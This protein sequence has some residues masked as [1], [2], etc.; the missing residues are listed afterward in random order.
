MVKRQ[1]FTL[2]E[3]I[4][5]LV[6]LVMITGLVQMAGPLTNQ[7]QGAT[8]K[9]TT[10][11]Y[12]FVKRLEDEQKDFTLIDVKKDQLTLLCTTNKLEYIV[13][14]GRQTVFL[15]TK[16]GGYLPVLV[17]YQPHTL[18]FQK[19]SETDVLVTC[20]LERGERK[21]AILHFKP[22]GKRLNHRHRSPHDVV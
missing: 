13:Q 1:G 9:D 5:S 7:V 4:I 8:L 17:N 11:W 10:D 3:C 20:Q 2:V 12:L 6:V 16:Q 15:K 22:S 14:G 21:N 19:L 18:D